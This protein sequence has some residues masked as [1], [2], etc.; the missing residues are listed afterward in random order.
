MFTP[1]GSP[2]AKLDQP[3]PMDAMQH[4]AARALFSTPQPSGSSLNLDEKH[5][6]SAST[7]LS[8]SS[9]SPKARPFLTPTLNHEFELQLPPSPTTS[10]ESKRRIGRRI[11]WT[12][13]AIPL[14]LI[15]V[16]LGN[17]CAVELLGMAGWI[18][19][20]TKSEGMHGSLFDMTFDE[21][22]SHSHH[23][24]RHAQGPAP[25]ASGET[26]LVR[27]QTSSSATASPTISALETPTSAVS[28]STSG[29]STA[30]TTIP[31][32]S[33]TIPSIP[34]STPDL[35]TPFPQPWDS[36]IAQNF[37]TTSCYNFFLNMTNMQDFRSCRPF[38]LL[39]STSDVFADLQTNLTALNDV[40]WGTCNPPPGIDQCTS[41]MSSYAAAL[42]SACTTDLAAS[43]LYAT[44]TLQALHAYSLTY[45]TGCAPD[46][47][48]NTYCYLRAAHN[49]NPSDLYFY[50]L[51]N[52]IAVANTTTPTCSACT[53]SVM[54]M[55]VN[56]LDVNGAQLAG[57]AAVYG[58]A[59][60][61]AT[62]TCGSGYAQVATGTE[63]DQKGNAAVGAGGS[64]SEGMRW[65]TAVAVALMVPV[66]GFAM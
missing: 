27:R 65:V 48:T 29:S 18:N 63:A 10:S 47:A 31:I 34:T 16:T 28:G 33:Q 14:I 44:S 42:Q 36:A 58:G 2:R 60:A 32:A 9:S 3:N 22:Q 5:S 49:S 56:A 39:E 50:N 17:H 21:M 43:N 62:S 11:K 35:P 57:L 45:S 23:S 8:S 66:L 4:E 6:T 25:S 1:P 54:S 52:G 61:L 7:Y 13:I 37:S 55:Y 30:S 64:S 15:L 19:D 40:I 12:A 26:Q 24:H 41:T 51:V 38:G 20:Q 46:P 59:E 53:K